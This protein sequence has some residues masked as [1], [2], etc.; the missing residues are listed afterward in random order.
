VAHLAAFTRLRAELDPGPARFAGHVAYYPAGVFGAIA[1]P[2]AY[3]GSPVLNLLGEKDDNAAGQSGELSGLREGCG[4]SGPGRNRYPGACRR[5][6]ARPGMAVRL[7]LNFDR[8]GAIYLGIRSF[9][10][11]RMDR[12]NARASGMFFLEGCVRKSS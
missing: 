7:L 12:A 5:Q 3:T 1:E 4:V 6:E 11:K 9:A 8:R 2:G 10:Q